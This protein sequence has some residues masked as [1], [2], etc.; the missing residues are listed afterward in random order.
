MT[1]AAKPRLYLD[2]I[3]DMFTA[4]RSPTATRSPRSPRNSSGRKPSSGRNASGGRSS[5]SSRPSGSGR[6][7]SFVRRV[8]NAAT[9]NAIT[10]DLSSVPQQP[11]NYLDAATTRRTLQ[12][13][14]QVRH[15]NREQW[16][17]QRSWRET[18]REASAASAV[19]SVSGARGEDG[20]TLD[21]AR[22]EAY[23]ADDEFERIFGMRKEAFYTLKPWRQGD[24]KKRVGLF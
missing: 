13:I 6:K 5:G 20:D 16:S 14:A 4:A 9:S 21:P 7:P 15:S 18:A 8:G 22:L 23:L 19:G 10:L 3:K 12:Q 11:L 24:L 17:G 2:A 1:T